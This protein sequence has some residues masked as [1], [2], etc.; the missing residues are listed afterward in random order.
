MADRFFVGDT[1]NSWNNSNNWS[2]TSGGAGGVGVPDT[3]DSA[4]FDSSSPG[5][6][7][8]ID[9]NIG[10]LYMSSGYSSVLDLN[11]Y[12]LI[13]EGNI[14]SDCNLDGGTL[15]IPENSVLT[16]KS[17]NLNFSGVTILPYDGAIALYCKDGITQYIKTG[18]SYTF[19][20]AVQFTHRNRGSNHKR[21][22][23]DGNTITV[24]GDLYL[25]GYRPAVSWSHFISNG[26]LIKDGP[27][28][29]ETGQRYHRVYG[30]GS[31]YWKDAGVQGNATLRVQGDGEV[32]FPRLYLALENIY[33]EKTSGTIVAQGPSLFGWR[34][35]QSAGI[36][37]YFDSPLDYETNAAQF[38][39]G[40]FGH[41]DVRMHG[42]EIPTLTSLRIN[43]NG[44]TGNDFIDLGGKT[45][46][47][48]ND[49]AIINKRNTW[50]SGINN[51]VIELHGNLTY[52]FSRTGG[53][54]GG[55]EG[56]AVI[57]MV[58]DND[59]YITG[60]G[61]DVYWNSLEINKPKRR[62]V[63]VI[64][65][66][67]KV[68]STRSITVKSGIL[69]TYQDLKAGSLTVQ[70]SAILE[71]LNDINIDV[72]SFINN[73]IVRTDFPD[74]LP[75]NFVN[76]RFVSPTHRPGYKESPRMDSRA[77]VYNKRVPNAFTRRPYK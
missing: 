8:D 50:H 36:D 63:F 75:N 35:M 41:G 33:F 26:T 29:I 59:S 34:F 65:S 42:D 12:S 74:S 28:V 72:L 49:L 51:G 48:K 47:V 54:Y 10:A 2:S 5:C 77:K 55:Y 56:S 53:G 31:S 7:L 15:R 4:I 6:V 3:S 70:N 71:L 66:G 23:L 24:T 32:T 52:Q 17:Q 9:G 60:T 27:G 25:Q 30:G 61:R 1:D 11:G 73:N 58:G 45:I 69:S 43:L 37:V 57:R 68:G 13:E 16:L 21:H 44:G 18:G 19:D 76:N 64:G 67:L 38:K 39:I 20:G 40:T 62:R 22:N 14:G 46:S